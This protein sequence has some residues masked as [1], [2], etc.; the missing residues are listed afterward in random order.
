VAPGAEK[1]LE[2]KTAPAVI[3]EFPLVDL[4]ALFETMPDLQTGEAPRLSSPAA[5][6]LDDERSL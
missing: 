4:P 5:E 2:A 1:A 3:I 6:P